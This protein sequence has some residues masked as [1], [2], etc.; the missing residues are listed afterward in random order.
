MFL[1][2]K[3][4]IPTTHTKITQKLNITQKQLNRLMKKFSKKKKKKK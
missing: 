3:K 2:E 1:D 4:V